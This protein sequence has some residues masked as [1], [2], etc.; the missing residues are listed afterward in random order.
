MHLGPKQTNVSYFLTDPLIEQ[1]FEY[2]IYF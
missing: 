2:F 1:Y